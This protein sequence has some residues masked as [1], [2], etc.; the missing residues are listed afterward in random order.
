M[1]VIETDAKP[2]ICRIAIIRQMKTSVV[3]MDSAI[4]AEVFPSFIDLYAVRLTMRQFED[5]DLE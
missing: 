5:W 1:G 4:T 2:V 3:N